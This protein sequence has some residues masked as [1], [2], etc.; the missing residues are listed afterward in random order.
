MLIYGRGIR[1]R[2]APILANDQRR[3][4]MA[5]SLLYSLPGT[6][7]LIYGDEIGM[8]EDLSRPGREA[9]RAPMQWTPEPQGG[10]STA[11]MGAWPRPMV[12]TAGFAPAQVNAQAQQSD[13]GSLLSFVKQLNRAHRDFP[14]VSCGNLEWVASDSEQVE[15]HIC[16]WRNDMV[17]SVHNLSGL[18]CT[19]RLDLKLIF[20]TDLVHIFGDDLKVARLSKSSLSVEMS[21][22]GHAWFHIKQ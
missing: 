12:S 18:A 13:S 2:L 6:P 20:F 8:G 1:R 5:L 4:R 17:L 19:A 22:Y 9:V 7:L 16:H 14:A 11:P 3:I 10:F 21:E 15:V